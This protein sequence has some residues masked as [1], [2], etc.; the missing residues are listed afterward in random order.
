MQVFIIAAMSLDGF[1]AQKEGQSS[2]DWTSG[3]DKKFFVEKTKEA[4]VVVMGRKTFETIGKALKDRLNIV[5]SREKVEGSESKVEITQKN[6]K[7]LIKDLENRGYKALA[8]CGGASIYSLFLKSGLV[9]KLFLTIEP[10]VFGKGVKLF[11]EEVRANLK[12]VSIKKLNGQGT[13]LV[14]YRN[15]FIKS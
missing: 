12:L 2:L 15:P 13:L 9:N 6:P 8:V 3:D 7:D 1:I 11:S 5:Y 10:V 14:E 4:G